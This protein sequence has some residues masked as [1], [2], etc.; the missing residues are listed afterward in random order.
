MPKKNKDINIDKAKNNVI[1]KSNQFFNN[2]FNNKPEK[3]TIAF[4]SKWIP[5]Y[6]DYISKEDNFLP[7]KKIE[8]KRG[9]VILVDYGVRLGKELGG[10]HY[11]VVLDAQNRKKEHILTVLPLKS[12]KQGH[13]KNGFRKYELPIGKIMDELIKDKNITLEKVKK[14]DLPQKIEKLKKKSDEIGV[15]LNEASDNGEIFKKIYSSITDEDSF[16]T[17]VNTFGL[18]QLN[19]MLK[20]LT[21]EIHKETTKFLAI[22]EDIAQLESD[23]DALNHEFNK[24]NL[25]I[26]QMNK[27]KNLK[28]D[29]CI[30]LNQVTSISKIR[31]IDPV[32][33][34]DSLYGI[35][36]PKRI[37]DE[38]TN[39]L[40]DFLGL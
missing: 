23:I 22:D 33:S 3:K 1:S 9:Q 25:E 6:L 11:S 18:G 4:I 14:I 27:I 12:V 2:E 21:E 26:A 30:I 29:S 5:T 10:K 7:E 16:Y 28:R 40:S 37:M 36:F 32:R 13:I 34:T 19:D 15:Q 35:R 17:L 39:N 8:Y 24:I 20:I 38:I 31:I